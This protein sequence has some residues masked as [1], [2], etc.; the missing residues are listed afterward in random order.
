MI[1]IITKTKEKIKKKEEEKQEQEPEL[2]EEQ[3]LL[4]E[5]RD[6]LKNK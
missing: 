1:K 3:K 2:S 4:T 6:I 5:I